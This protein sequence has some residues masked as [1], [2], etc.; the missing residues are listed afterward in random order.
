LG[1]VKFMFPN[2]FN[3]YLHDTNQRYLFDNNTRSFSSGCIRV[4]SPQMLASYLL[5]RNF[6]S[7]KL[8]EL[9]E[10]TAPEQISI[11]P[12]TVHIQYW[13]AWV[14]RD[15]LVNFRPDIYFRDLDLDVALTEPAYRVIDQLQVSAGTRLAKNEN[16]GLR[17]GP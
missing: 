15:G 17:R 6:G 7:G 10:A 3:V 13:T 1:R 11:K 16:N 9:F 4:K 8:Q 12:L 5:G 2:R 14:D